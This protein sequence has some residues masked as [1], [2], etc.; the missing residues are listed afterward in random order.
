MQRAIVLTFKR[1]TNQ[2]SIMKTSKTCPKCGGTEI[3]TNEGG[4]SRGDRSSIE[5]SSWGKF[6]INT[7]ACFSCGY[8]EEY[9]KQDNLNDAKKMDK[10]RSAWR[11]A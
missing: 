3:Y 10:A 4:P 1:D 7:Y 11:K 9:I 5:F 8:I 2:T 6:F